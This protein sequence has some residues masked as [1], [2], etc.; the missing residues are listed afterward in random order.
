MSLKS[1]DDGPVKHFVRL[2]NGQVC[3]LEEG[4]NELFLALH[5]PDD[6]DQRW[7]CSVGDFGVMAFHFASDASESLVTGLKGEEKTD[8]E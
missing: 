8:D 1:T 7:I 2:S 4:Q 3:C 5:N 6:G